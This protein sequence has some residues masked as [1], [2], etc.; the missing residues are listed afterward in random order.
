MVISTLLKYMFNP[1]HETYFWVC[2]HILYQTAS[3]PYMEQ[4]FKVSQFKELFTKETI[5]EVEVRCGVSVII[6]DLQKKS[7]YPTLA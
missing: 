1:I 6:W 5:G 7:Y 3:K 2:S 4:P